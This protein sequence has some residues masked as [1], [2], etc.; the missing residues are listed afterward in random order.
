MA[1]P[2][3][4]GEEAGG[5]P[6]AGRSLLFYKRGWVRDPGHELLLL[7]VHL[8]LP[9]S[10]L[11]R[12]WR[13]PG[14]GEVVAEEQGNGGPGSA[15]AALRWRRGEAARGR[16]RPSSSSSPPQSPSATVL[17]RIEQGPWWKRQSSPPLLRELLPMPV[18]HR[19]GLSPALA[20]WI[21]CRRAR[22]HLCP[23]AI[24]LEQ[25]HDGPS[26][27]P[28]PATVRRPGLRQLESLEAQ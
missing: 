4:G 14:S 8:F 25:G 12:R 24:A 18:A 23:P 19:L 2:H 16:C 22:L 13:C 11:W 15:A 26:S 21:R 3:S 27:I 1:G 10:L 6:P 5:A 17:R 20:W 9:P 28:P 7:P